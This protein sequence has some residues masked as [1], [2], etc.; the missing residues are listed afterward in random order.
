MEQRRTPLVL[1]YNQKWQGQ[2]LIDVQTAIDLS[3]TT[4]TATGLTMIC[5]RDDSE[6]GL[7]QKVSDEDFAAINLVKI[8]P[9]ELWNYRILP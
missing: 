7:A 2:P 5:V 3:G 6:Y 8:T 1:L 4:R 9:F